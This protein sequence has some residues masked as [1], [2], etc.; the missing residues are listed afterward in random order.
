VKDGYVVKTWG[1]VSAKGDWASAAKPVISTLLF[2]AI[3]EGLIPSVDDLISNWGWDLSTK[4]E[5]MTFYHLANMISGYARPEPPGEAWAYNDYAIRLYGLT[6]QG[7][8]D[9][10]LD[11]ATQLRLAPL[12]FEDGSLFGSRNGL[13]LYT[14]VRDFARIGWLWL[15]KGHWNGSQLLPRSYFDAYMKPLVPPDLPRTSPASTDDYLGIGTYG[16]GS[17]QFR[18]GPGIY[19][20]NWWF[21]E[22]VGGS[23]NMIWPDAP[24]DAFAADGGTEV[25]MV[26]P[27]L[28]MVVAAVGDWGLWDPGNPN[29]GMN[30]NLRLLKEAVGVVP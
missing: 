24:A 26:I 2:F 25:V 18:E 8:F 13:G 19:G 22:E 16:G 20:F 4:D 10:T 1:S 9:T 23:G 30:Q 21:N 3:E 28:N 11:E 15:N 7:V 29:A 6:M 17:D 5:T 14:S 27:S 12:Q